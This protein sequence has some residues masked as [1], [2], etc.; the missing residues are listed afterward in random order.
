M[1]G[2]LSRVARGAPSPAATRLRWLALSVF[3]ISSSLNYADRLL[4][5]ALAPTI[6][7]EFHL[8][9][10]GYGSVIS[11]F[12]LVYAVAAPLAGWVVDRV[13][14]NAGITLAMTVWSLA[15]AA[16][17]FTRGL[18]GLLACRTVLGV[19]EAAGIP[20]TAK[21]NGLYLGAQDLAFGTALNQVGITVGAVAAPLLVAALAPAYGWRFSFMLCGLAGFAWLPLWWFTSRRVPARAAPSNT[22]SVPI[23]TILR[24]RRMWGLIGANALVMTLYTLWTNWTTLYLVQERHLSEIAANRQF[25]WIPPLAATL[26]GFCGGWLAFRAIRSGVA[27]HAARM[28]VCWIS[29]LVLLATAVVPLAPTSALAAAAI[30]VSFFWCLAISTNLYAMPI[31]WYGAGRAAFGVSMITC[32]FGLMTALISPAIGSVVDHFGFAPVCVAMAVLPLVGIAILHAS[33]RRGRGA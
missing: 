30:S 19:G 4:L 8:S 22:A 5:A 32:S 11:V 6:K 24:D 18:G 28:R 13:G 7:D 15:G 12:S 3:V 2:R 14:L 20:C 33:T 25:A 26:G 23:A 16:T 27:V 29:G 31:D 1:P 17:G 10:A 9:N 21:A